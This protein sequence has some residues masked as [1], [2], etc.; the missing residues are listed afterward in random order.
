[1]YLCFVVLYCILAQSPASLACLV[2]SRQKF[3]CE[4]VDRTLGLV[5]AS[6]H[7][8]IS[9]CNQLQDSPVREPRPAARHFQP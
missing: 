9:M 4:L 6:S 2:H 8:L 7:A 3:V 5:A 1:M